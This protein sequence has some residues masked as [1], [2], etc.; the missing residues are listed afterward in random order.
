[1]AERNI[2]PDG[3]EG[4]REGRGA[5]DNVYIFQHLAEKE[6]SQNATRMYALRSSISM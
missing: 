2:L 6:L 4:I 3:Q 1:M 5:M